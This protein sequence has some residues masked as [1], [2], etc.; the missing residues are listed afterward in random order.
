MAYLFGGQ[1]IIGSCR[2]NSAAG[3]VM[4][5]ITKLTLISTLPSSAMK[6]DDPRHNIL[7]RIM[8]L[9]KMHLNLLLFT[10]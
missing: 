7:G 1:L 9:R 10:A 4:A 6:H 5:E 2:H 3:K 8:P